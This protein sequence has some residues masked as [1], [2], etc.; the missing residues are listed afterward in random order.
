M[1]LVVVA[2]DGLQKISQI[3]GQSSVGAAIVQ[4]DQELIE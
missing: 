2:I 1:L 3:A 4:V